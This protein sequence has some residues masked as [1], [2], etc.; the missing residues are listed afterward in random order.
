[1]V[2]SSHSTSVFTSGSHISSIRESRTTYLI[3]RVPTC[4][5]PI[6]RWFLT[7]KKKTF[8]EIILGVVNMK[9]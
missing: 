5:W 4:H 1:V 7:K 3:V 2:K 8:M 9:A 6:D